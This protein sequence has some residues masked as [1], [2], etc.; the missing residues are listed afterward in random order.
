MM[1]ENESL[2]GIVKEI[3]ILK[4]EPLLGKHDAEIE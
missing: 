2:N 4:H 1:K 3:E